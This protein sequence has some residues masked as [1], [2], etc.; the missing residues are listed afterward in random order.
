MRAAQINTEQAKTKSDRE[1]LETVY[2]V[3]VTADP[4]DLVPDP[5]PGLIERVQAVQLEQEHVATALTEHRTAVAEKLEQDHHDV[6]ALLH[7]HALKDEESFAAITT[8]L[9][10]LHPETGT[11]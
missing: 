3:L 10:A 4:T 9:Q 11:G 2:S 8:A 6:T 5:P 1:L 7:Q